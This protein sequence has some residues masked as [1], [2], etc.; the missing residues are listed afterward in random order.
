[1]DIKE[2]KNNEVS[3]LASLQPTGWQNILPIFDFYT[4]SDFCFSVK[5]NINNKI[6]GIGA[7]IIHNEIAWLAHIIVH[8]ENRNKGI[9]NLITQALI[10]ISDTQKCQTIYLIATDLGAPVYE[11][12]GFRTETEYLFFKNIN[13]EKKWTTSN[14]IELFTNDFKTQIADLDKQVS[15]EKR[16]FHIERHIQNG[17]VYKENNILEGFYL[18]S[19]GEGLIIANTSSAG[20][21]LMKMRLNTKKDAI[22]PSNNLMAKDFMNNNNHT[23]NSKAKRMILG[24]ERIVLYK[25]IYNRIGGNIG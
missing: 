7:L 5:V 1:M 6:I 23:E 13:N 20:L 19:F 10:N 8:K 17:Y 11:K 21:E 2:L 25:N 15:G 24:K 12:L 4:N 14:N 18:P 3:H 22:F 9:G 16:M